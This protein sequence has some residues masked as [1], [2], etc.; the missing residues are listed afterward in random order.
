MSNNQDKF[1]EML[2]PKTTVYD[3]LIDKDNVNTNDNT[4]LPDN[5]DVNVTNIPVA[6]KKTNIRDTHKSKAFYIRKEIAK[7]IEQDIRNS[8][9]GDMTKIANAL[10]EEYYRS[11]GRLK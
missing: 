11:Q 3:E 10:F 1:K 9:R 5:V 2:K 8:S 4:N 6:K 7:L